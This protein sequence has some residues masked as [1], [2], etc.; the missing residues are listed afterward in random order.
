MSLTARGI[1]TVREDYPQLYTALLDITAAIN[2]QGAILGTN[3][4]GTVAPPS[5]SAPCR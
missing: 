1:D 4:A 3:P 5:M 2:Q